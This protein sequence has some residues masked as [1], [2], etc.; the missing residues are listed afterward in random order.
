M[1]VAER[2][3]A[4][5][6]AVLLVQWPQAIEFRGIGFAI[7]IAAGRGLFCAR[8]TLLGGF[9]MLLRGCV[10]AWL[11]MIGASAAAGER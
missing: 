8:W 5:G 7:G 10:F 4:V 1:Q 3:Q 11:L 9:N 6:P 2:A